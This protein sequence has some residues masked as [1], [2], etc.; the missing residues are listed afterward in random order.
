MAQVFSPVDTLVIKLVLVAVAGVLVVA[1]LVYRLN[2]RADAP[3]LAPISQPIPFSH[4]HHVGDDGIDCRY[5]H[6]SVEHSAFAGIPP[7]Q[8]CMTCHSQ[9]YTRQPMFEPLLTAYRG[10]KPLEWNRVNDL[11]GFVYFDH[12]I[13]VAKG[14]GCAECHGQVDRMPLMYRYASLN[15]QWCLDCHRDPAP[16]LRPRDKVFDMRWQPD[17][18]RRELGRKL[19][20]AYHVRSP[21]ELTQCSVCHR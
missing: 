10:G 9:L 19:A 21:I 5:C 17:G 3:Q 11:P 14:V 20:A 16:H 12:S 15:M 8:T 2:V 1:G 18:D 4:Q 13:H 7:L 6:T